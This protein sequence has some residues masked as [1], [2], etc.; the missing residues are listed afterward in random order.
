MVACQFV[1]Q[2]L[3]YR[4]L[5]GLLTLYGVV[6]GVLRT[7]A[8]AN[9][10]AGAGAVARAGAGASDAASSAAGNAFSW[11]VFVLGC[12]SG[13]CRCARLFRHLVPDDAAFHVVDQN[14][15]GSLK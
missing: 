1:V 12:G 3:A 6:G 10:E 13:L 15:Y 8:T 7:A 4:L 9:A 11:L 5:R 2:K 14:F